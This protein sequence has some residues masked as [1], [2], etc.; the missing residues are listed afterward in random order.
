[1][2]DR[3][4]ADGE[5]GRD[6]A[7]AFVAVDGAA[8][9]ATARATGCGEVELSDGSGLKVVIR[10]GAGQAVDVAAVVM[11]VRTAAR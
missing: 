7:P 8:L 4:G 5:S 2:K 1:L 6:G 11:A 10:L 9:F 3:L